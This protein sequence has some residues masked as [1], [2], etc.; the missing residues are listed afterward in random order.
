M[1]L[2]FFVLPTRVHE[3]YLY[4]AFAVGAILAATSIRWRIA[5]IGLALASFAN[6]YAILLTPFYK[7]PGI[8][9]GWG[10]ATQFVRRSGSA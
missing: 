3:R 9:D 1:A 6:L 5:Y 10:S 2:V 8:K 7:N 4:P